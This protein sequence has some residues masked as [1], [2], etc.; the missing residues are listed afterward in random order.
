MACKKLTASKT[1]Q[2]TETGRK[3]TLQAHWL[4]LQLSM[5]KGEI[6]PLKYVPHLPHK[7]F[8]KAR[9]CPSAPNLMKHS[10]FITYNADLHDRQAH[11]V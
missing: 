5:E 2:S 6:H 3:P 1:L 7:V 4:A 9:D 11:T 10:W 8:L